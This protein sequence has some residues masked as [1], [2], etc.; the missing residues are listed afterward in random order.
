[1]VSIA[2]FLAVFL[3]GFANA[4]NSTIRLKQYN[5][6]TTEEYLYEYD[7]RGDNRNSRTLQHLSLTAQDRFQGPNGGGGYFDEYSQFIDYYGDHDYADKWITAAYRF[8]NTNF[9][10]G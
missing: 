7:Q 8:E 5:G 3:A 6:S 10:N 9:T 4:A 1:M 2:F